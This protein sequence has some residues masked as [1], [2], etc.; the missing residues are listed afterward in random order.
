[1]RKLGTPGP[2]QLLAGAVNGSVMPSADGK[3]LLPVEGAGAFE[4][5]ENC[6]TL[7]S[8]S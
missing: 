8:V 7:I 5:W 3:S 4:R 1:M 2:T 6:D